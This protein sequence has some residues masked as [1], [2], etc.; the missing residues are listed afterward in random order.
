VRTIGAEQDWSFHDSDWSWFPI[1]I[2]KC[3][4]QSGIPDH[5]PHPVRLSRGRHTLEI[6]WSESCGDLAL[7]QVAAARFVGVECRE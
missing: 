2:R 7:D 4:P 1:T 3:A 5:V 6:V